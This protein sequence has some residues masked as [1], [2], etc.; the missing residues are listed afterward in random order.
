MRVVEKSMQRVLA[1]LPVLVLLLAAGAPAEIYRWTDA[2]GRLHFTQRLDQVPPAHRSAARRGAAKE[3]RER[4]SPPA[5]AQRAERSEPRRSRRRGRSDGLVIPFERMGS[6]M[7]VDVRLN[8]Y[9]V[10]PFL[11]DTGAS[12]VSLPSAVAEQLGIR[13]SPETPTV[14]LHTANGVVPRSLVTLDAVELGGARVEGLQA[15]VNPTMEIGLLGGTFFNNF[16]YQVDA[17]QSVI[18][19][20]PN[21]RV[22]GGLTAGEWGSR[23][24]ELRGPL[25]RLDDYL[26]SDVKIRSRDRERLDRHRAE[27]ERAL[28]ELEDEANRLGVP[29][30]W[31]SP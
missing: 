6:V 31:R 24:E 7:K 8:D 16:V 9:L 27:L 19:L 26:A 12:G 2:Q 20:K 25:A 5:A 23:F 18:R 17:A 30:K 11:I 10:A 29:Y 28:R 15:T 1:P 14:M 3:L 22:K 13:V 4:E 21:D